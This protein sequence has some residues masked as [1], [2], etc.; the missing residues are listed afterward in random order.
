MTRLSQRVSWPLLL[1]ASVFLASAVLAVHAAMRWTDGRLIYSLDD[2]Y[3][4]MALAKNLAHHGVWGCTPFH[5]SSSSSS[6][7]WTAVLAAAY[8]VFGVRDAIP[9]V[10]NAALALATL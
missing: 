4:H 7:L 9:L 8:R 10:L 3:I 6:L 5:F 1:S 2:A